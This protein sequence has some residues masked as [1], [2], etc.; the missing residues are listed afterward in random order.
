[1][2]NP[3]KEVRTIHLEARYNDVV[4]LGNA[5]IERYRTFKMVI[6]PAVNR[7]EKEEIKTLIEEGFLVVNKHGNP[8]SQSNELQNVHG[9]KV[10]IGKFKDIND[11]RN[12]FT[13]ESFN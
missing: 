3:N 4:V 8:E 1:M 11:D 10:L 2:N 13:L 7:L 5:Q 9:S 6:E 12:E